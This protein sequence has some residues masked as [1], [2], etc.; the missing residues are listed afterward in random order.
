MRKSFC[1]F[2]FILSSSNKHGLVQKRVQEESHQDRTGTQ[3]GGG[4]GET[5]G[6]SDEEER[7]KWRRG[8]GERVPVSRAERCAV[9]HLQAGRQGCLG[10]LFLP[11]YE[12]SVDGLQPSGFTAEVR[13]Q[14]LSQSDHLSRMTIH[15]HTHLMDTQTHRAPGQ[16][17]CCVMLQFEFFIQLIC[18]T[19]SQVIE[20]KSHY[21]DFSSTN[22]VSSF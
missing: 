10:S 16:S 3:R 6:E 22:N 8:Q 9:H 18:Q 5:E 11:G 15:N 20:N 21:F 7:L 4:R 12:R 14:L 17:F 2:P 1:C 13:G 19:I